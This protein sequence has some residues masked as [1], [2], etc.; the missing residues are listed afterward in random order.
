MNDFSQYYS[1][2]TNDIDDR[3]FLFTQIQFDWILKRLQSYYSQDDVFSVMDL[4]CGTGR[5]L[6]QIAG[7]FPNAHLY[8][9]DGTRAMVQKS[10]NKLH[11]KANIIQADLNDYKPS[12]DYDV[13]ISTTVLHHLD[14]PSAH[15]AM[16]KNHTKQHIFISEFAI[17]T[18]P[19]WVAN[20]CWKYSQSSHKQAWSPSVFQSLIRHNDFIIAD[21]AILKPDNF[22]R[23]Q[24]Y[25]MTV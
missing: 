13:I 7:I 18:L 20:L 8:G 12:S 4:G 16:I 9:V 10:K 15:L 6:Y 3:W 21:K 1:K 23:L 19:L 24:I 2:K 5:L 14:N 11:D 17:M 22:W 25:D